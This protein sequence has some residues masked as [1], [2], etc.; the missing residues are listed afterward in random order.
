M[1]QDWIEQSL[2]GVTI[3]TNNHFEW[4]KKHLHG[5]ISS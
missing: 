4:A 3:L 1:N 5:I 2:T